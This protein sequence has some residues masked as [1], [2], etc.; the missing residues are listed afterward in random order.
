MNRAYPAYRLPLVSCETCG[1]LEPGFSWQDPSTGRL[2]GEGVACRQARMA[3]E[4]CCSCRR[5]KAG[6]GD[7]FAFCEGCWSRKMGDRG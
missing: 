4:P 1:N 2:R 6:H 5:E 7:D 3:E